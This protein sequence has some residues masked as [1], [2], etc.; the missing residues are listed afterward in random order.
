MHVFPVQVTH[1]LAVATRQ[2]AIVDTYAWGTD[3]SRQG[4][5]H[6]RRHAGHGV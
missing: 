1:V 3:H 2:T 6:S 5:S 4:P